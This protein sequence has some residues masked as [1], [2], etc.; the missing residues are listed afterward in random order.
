MC[1]RDS[2][3]VSCRRDLLRC[4]ARA[5]SWSSSE[6]R[7]REPERSGAS[8]NSKRCLLRGGMALE[9]VWL[10]VRPNPSFVFASSSEIHPEIAGAGFSRSLA[11]LSR[12]TDVRGGRCSRMFCICRLCHLCLSGHK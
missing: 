2:S 12:H 1:I 7:G 6:V 3:V 11:Q 8:N 4:A 5:L 9:E 10:A